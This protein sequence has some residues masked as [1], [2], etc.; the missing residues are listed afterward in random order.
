[1]K[2]TKSS[3]IATLA[4]SSAFAGGNINDPVDVTVLAPV[5]EAS[6]TTIS[7]KAQAYYYSTDAVDLFDA[8]SSAL[9][10]AVTLDV[11]HTLFDGVTANFTAL[12]YA[13][14]MSEN[15]NNSYLEGQEV[16]AYFN[17]ANITANFGKTTFILGRQ[18]MDSPMFGSFD[19]LLAPSSF[20]AYTVVNNSI[21]NLTLVGT[22][23]TKM[24]G[25]NSGN[26]FTDLTEINGGDNYA[27]GAVYAKDALSTSAWYY[28]IDAGDYTQV[29]VDAGYD[30]GSVSVAAQYATTDYAT[31]LDSDAYAVKAETK[32]GD[33]AL[34]AAVSSVTDM[35]AGIVERDNF[36]T[37]SWNSFA[38]TVAVANEDTLSWKVSASTELAGLNAEASYAG[39]GDEGSEFDLILGYDASKSVNLAMIYTSTDYDVNTDTAEAENALEVIA[40]YTF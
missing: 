36:Y 19:W 1:M 4:I 39:Y 32:V 23:V 22:Y 20:E 7:G 2:I 12:G 28:N 5:I 33:I 8:D 16:G 10:T 3:L 17:V 6:S 14:A 40:T 38:S 24:R 21:D 9:G 15:A 25:V 27:F 29:Y 13:N 34:M 11:S 30:F 35:S 31:G 37:S 18:L 26:T